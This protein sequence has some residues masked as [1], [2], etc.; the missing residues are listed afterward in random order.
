M[1][2]G[3]WSIEAGGQYD[4]KGVRVIEFNYI[5]GATLWSLYL[6]APQGEVLKRGNY[7]N[8][9]RYPFQSSSQPGLSFSGNGRGC[10]EITGEFT[11][12]EIVLGPANR[13]ERLHVEFEQY[14]D[15]LAPGLLGEVGLL[16]NP[17]R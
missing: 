15:N 6:S 9:A 5:D 16:A 13:V 3:T 7:A 8:A 12:H 17:W 4:P 2:S 11:I 10:N 1:E 14:C